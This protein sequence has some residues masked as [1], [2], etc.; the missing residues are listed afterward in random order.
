MTRLG[1][2]ILLAALLFTGPAQAG[3]IFLDDYENLTLY[4]VITDVLRTPTLGY[5]A[6]WIEPHGFAIRPR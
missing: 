5:S 2:F 6:I 4:D 1:P 3:V